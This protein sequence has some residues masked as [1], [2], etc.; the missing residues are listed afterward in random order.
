MR[1]LCRLGRGPSS[2]SSPDSDGSP[3]P[4]SSDR[5]RPPRAFGLVEL[6]VVIAIVAILAGLLLPALG[7]ARE[8]ANRTKCLSNLRQL[9]LAFTA[10]LNDNK[11]RYPRPAQNAVQTSEDWVHFQSWRDPREGSIAKYL[12]DTFNAAVYRCPSDD[13]NSHRRFT[14]DSLTIQYPYSYTV[15]E[16]ICRIEWRGPTLRVNQIRNPSEKILIID[17]AATTIDDGCWAWQ[18]Q[19]GGNGNA[20]PRNVLSNRHDRQTERAPQHKFGR[21]NAAFVDGHVAFIGRGESFD[22]RYFDP[23]R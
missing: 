2:S 4:N 22:A 12:G 20:D 15:N 1:V 13:P 11:G 10:Y 9:A 23:A 19:L 8:S 5:A 18:S 16:M 14:L 17:E 21:G 6:M 7:R 3:G